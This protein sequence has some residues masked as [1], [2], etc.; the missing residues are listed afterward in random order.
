MGTTNFSSQKSNKN[1][2]NP[3]IFEQSRDFR[4]VEA[5]GVE[6]KSPWFTA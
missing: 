4:L 5:G 2:E 1:S 3:V 6:P